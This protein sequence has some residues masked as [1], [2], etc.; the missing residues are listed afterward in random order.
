MGKW[1]VITVYSVATAAAVGLSS[2]LSYQCAAAVKAVSSAAVTAAVAAI[3]VTTVVVTIHVVA[4]LKSSG[5]LCE[6]RGFLFCIKNLKR[7]KITANKVAK[8]IMQKLHFNSMY[9]AE[10]FDLHN[11]SDP[12]A[13]PLKSKSLEHSQRFLTYENLQKSA[14]TQESES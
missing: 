8:Q 1:L 6:S 9:S 11:I 13:A 12:F 3:A 14:K 5:N 10:N 2:F 7:S 4:K